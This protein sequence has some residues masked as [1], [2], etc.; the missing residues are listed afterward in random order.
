MSN[1][2][3]VPCC[4]ASAIPSSSIKL[5]CS[6]ESMPARIASLIDCVP[7]ACAAT[8]RPSLCASSAMACI[9]SSV[10]CGVPGWSPLLNTPPEAHILIRSAPY[11]TVSRTNIGVAARADVAHG[12]EAGAQGESRIFGAGNGFARNRNA[13]PLIAAAVGISRKVRVHIDQTRE[14]RGARKIDRDCPTRRRSGCRRTHRGNRAIR[15]EHD[16]LVREHPS[17]PHIQ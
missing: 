17:G 8:L 15:V 6:I 13:E 5:L 3:Y 2:R 4:F 7:C 12:G 1:T 11:F 9:S 14:A 10:Y 16:D